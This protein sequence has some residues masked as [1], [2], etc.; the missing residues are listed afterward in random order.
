MDGESSPPTRPKWRK[1]AYGGM[2][3]GYDDNYTDESFLE[4]MV[5]N[6]NVVK[7]DL[8]KVMRDSVSISQ[9]I[10]IVVLVGVVWT[11]TLNSSLSEKSL[12]LIDATLL[13][14]GFLILLLT[15]KMLSLNQLLHYL[16]N[17]AFFTSGLYVL[18]PIYRTLT[19]SISSDSI[20]AVTVSLLIIHLFLHDYSR[21]TG[22]NAAPRSNFAASYEKDLMWQVTS[23]ERRTVG[24]CRHVPLGRRTAAVG[25]EGLQITTKQWQAPSGLRCVRRRLLDLARLTVVPA[26]QNEQ[27]KFAKQQLKASV[28]AENPERWGWRCG[29]AI[30]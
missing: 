18:A 24:Q 10:C 22:S 1:V 9:Y 2:Q 27:R 3:P 5:T 21:S 8:L 23:A 29:G 20:W 14:S 25:P 16:A 26:F 19:T 4:D 30:V 28:L 17:V 15:E 13:M 11:Y 6:A 7:R 12:L